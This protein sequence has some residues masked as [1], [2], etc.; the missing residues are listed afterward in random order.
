MMW[1]FFWSSLMLIA[2]ACAFGQSNAKLIDAVDP[3]YGGRIRQ[4]EK[5]GGHEHNLYYHRD[6]WNAD[7]SRMIGIHSDLQQK[8]WRVVLYDGD[9][10]FI[11][12]LFPIDKYDWRLVWDRNDPRF[13][14]TWKGM[15]LFRY[16]VTSDKADLLKSFD[17]LALKPNGPSLNQA[18]DRILVITSDG[19]YRSYRL[20]EMQ[21][22]RAFNPAVPAGYDVDWGKPAYIGCRNYIHT[23]FKPR[24]PQGEAYLMVYDDAGKVIHRFDGIGGGGHY[25]FSPEGKLAYFKMPSGGRRGGR[26]GGGGGSPL[27]IHVVDLD[28]ANDKILFSASPSQA[29]YL[30][31]LHLSWPDKVNDWFIASFFP[32]AGNLPPTYAPL[33]DE[34]LLIRL[35]GTC[36]YLARTGTAYSRAGGKGA[37]GDMFWAQPL[38]SPSADGKRI[39]FNSN[40]SGTIDQHILYVD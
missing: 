3:T 36:K 25:D 4:I 38:A 20:P 31:N 18:G 23:A 33:L 9:G 10:Q 32:N 37:E 27:E 22:E 35:S 16:D 34:I 2:N 30:Q 1:R 17:P 11:K 15:D 28:G 7:S 26:R 29:K 40:R 12:E 19:A 5:P 39:C 13:L 21:E 14:Y 8:N 6:P 24:D